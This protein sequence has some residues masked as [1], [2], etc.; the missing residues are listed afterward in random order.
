MPFNT[1]KQQD[2]FNT[3]SKNCYYGER[4]MECFQTFT[5][6]LLGVLKHGRNSCRVAFNSPKVQSFIS[7][8]KRYKFDAVIAELFV[9]EIMY[10]FAHILNVP[11]ILIS[12]FDYD[13]PNFVG[14]GLHSIFSNS[15]QMEGNYDRHLSFGERIFNRFFSYWMVRF[16][17]HFHIKESDKIV[18]EIFWQFGKLPSLLEIERKASLLIFNSLEVLKRSKLRDHGFV[19]I[20][21]IHIKPP[22]RMEDKF[23]VIF[24]SV[25]YFETSNGV[26]YRTF[27]TMQSVALSTLVLAQ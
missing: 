20:A 18:N 5:N 8:L 14:N 2:I 25:N 22:Q 16:R 27:S 13:A 21:G 10:I 24:R 3:W 23:Q 19:N 17:L 7:K 9:E 11:L 1:V 12:S 6:H 26:A 4:S 15:P